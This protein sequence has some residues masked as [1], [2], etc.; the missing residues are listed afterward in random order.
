MFTMATS[1]V[2]IEKTK[3]SRKRIFSI[4]RTARRHYHYRY[5]PVHQYYNILYYTINIKKICINNSVPQIYC[6][7]RG[8]FLGVS[9]ECE[10]SVCSIILP[11]KR[12]VYCLFL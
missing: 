2:K 4:F 7:V 12:S 10:L 11:L 1:L 8:V 3:K 6:V 9:P 5:V